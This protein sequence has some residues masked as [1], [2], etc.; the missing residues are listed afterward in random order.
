MN[1]TLARMVNYF[2]LNMIP[3]DTLQRYIYSKLILEGIIYDSWKN[4]TP[5]GSLNIAKLI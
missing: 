5:E 2:Q 1:N 3:D 4:V